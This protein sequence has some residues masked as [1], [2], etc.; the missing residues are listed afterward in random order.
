MLGTESEVV[1]CW[2]FL[3]NTEKL[4][5][6]FHTEA[7]GWA[8]A[9]AGP[10]VQKAEHSQKGEAGRSEA[11]TWEGQERLWEQG[12]E[13]NLLSYRWEPTKGSPPGWPGAAL[14]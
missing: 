9:K 4:P 11:I 13:A 8:T 7:T 14:S 10:G 5:E 1:R 3:Q 6:A 12:K 2:G